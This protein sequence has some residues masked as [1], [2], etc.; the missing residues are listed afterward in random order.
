M[1]WT[2]KSSQSIFFLKLDFSKT[3]DIIEYNFLFK[4]LNNMEFLQKFVE[5]EKILLIIIKASIK[6]NGSFSTFFYD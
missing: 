2:K 1:E 6:I 3:Y 4:K 5:I